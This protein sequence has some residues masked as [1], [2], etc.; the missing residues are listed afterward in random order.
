MGHFNLELTSKMKNCGQTIKTQI[1][2][3]FEET[4][5]TP[6]WTI[7]SK[8]LGHVK[9]PPGV[10][11]LLSYIIFNEGYEHDITSKK[12]RLI[13]SISQ[14]ICRDATQGKWKLPMYVGLGMTVR[15]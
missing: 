6:I 9:L 2:C 5:R 15:H 1:K 4:Q 3:H 7:T 14:D 12:T 8:S 13:S 10:N 11:E